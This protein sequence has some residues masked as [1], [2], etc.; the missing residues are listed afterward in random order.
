MERDSGGAGYRHLRL[1]GLLK[2]ELAS[3]FR[4]DI[5]DPALF[6]LHV[7]AVVLSVDYRNARVHFTLP[8]ALEGSGRA[9]MA[10]LARATPFLRARLA[11]ALDLK[12]V[13]Q[14]R[15]VCD[16]F[17]AADDDAAAAEEDPWRS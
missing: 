8:P 5:T 2:D 12:Q 4:D 10:A 3:L 13:P 17:A 9:P 1:Q 16:G 15:F 6:G 7:R 11:D 14:L